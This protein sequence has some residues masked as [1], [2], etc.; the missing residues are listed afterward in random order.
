MGTNNLLLTNCRHVRASFSALQAKQ[1]CWQWLSEDQ[2]HETR[3]EIGKQE[4]SDGDMRKG[5]TEQTQKLTNN[6]TEW[7]F[8]RVRRKTRFQS[9]ENNTLLANRRN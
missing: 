8:T 6:V 9:Q 5:L 2:L 7:V 3:S 4:H 1:A